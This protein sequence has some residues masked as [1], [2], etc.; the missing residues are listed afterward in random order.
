MTKKKV[1]VAAAFLAVLLAI[2][3]CAFLTVLKADPPANIDAATK[4]YLNMD[5]KGTERI[6]RRILALPEGTAE[7]KAE[8]LIMQARIAWKFYQEPE[9]ARDLLAQAAAL[10]EKEYELYSTLSRVERESGRF[11]QA[12]DAANR[13]IELAD[14]QRQWVDARDLW[15]QA[16]WE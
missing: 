15:A 16:V 14:S 10:E 12:R 6:V 4:L 8:A 9:R 7:S 1:I 5:L 3:L 13:V 11:E 2:G